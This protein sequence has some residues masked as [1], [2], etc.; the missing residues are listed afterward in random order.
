MDSNHL[1]ALLGRRAGP[2]RVS[3]PSSVSH[4]SGNERPRQMQAGWAQERDRTQ[5]P[6]SDR[7][8]RGADLGVPLPT[9]G[10]RTL[11]TF[12]SLPPPS[13][14]T[15]IPTCSCRLPPPKRD[16]LPQ[17]QIHGWSSPASPGC[18]L[19]TPTCPVRMKSAPLPAPCLWSQTG[20][21]RATVAQLL[22]S[23]SF[24][25]PRSTLRRGQH[26]SARHLP[27]LPAPS[28]TLHRGPVRPS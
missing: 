12:H 5:D 26:L 10:T 11:V 27:G 21:P 22:S 20:S 23:V 13:S 8:G 25:D 2:G 7:S 18:P 17:A 28:L 15:P 4:S 24:Y 9:T 1:G 19:P 6:R 16:S 14:A 3:P